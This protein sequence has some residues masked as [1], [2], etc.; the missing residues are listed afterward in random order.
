MIRCFLLLIVILLLVKK[1]SYGK[2]YF[3]EYKKLLIKFYWLNFMNIGNKDVNI[4]I[5]V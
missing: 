3:I 1:R 5:I 4:L 2:F